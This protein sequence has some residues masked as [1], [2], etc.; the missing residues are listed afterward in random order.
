MSAR[1][2]LAT[3]PAALL[4]VTVALVSLHRMATT[5]PARPAAAP[6]LLPPAAAAPVAP[7][8]HPSVAPAPAA[9]PATAPAVDGAW[10]AR[11]AS[12]TGIPEAALRAYAA[13]QLSGVGGCPV[14]WTTLAGI[15]W[16]ES[17]HGTIDG[18]LLGED[19][20][21]TR[22]VVGPPLD[23]RGDVAAIRSTAASRAWH[24]D[25]VWEHAVGP[26][27]FLRPSF[28]RWAADGDGDGV[29]D[30]HDL[31][32]AAAT[33]ARY[34]CGTGHDLT[35]GEGWVA[36]VLDYNRSTE[37]VEQ[38]RTAAQAYADRSAG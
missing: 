3:A 31:D 6:G 35:T 18:R 10:L 4:A 11:T 26:M 28:D 33:A 5:E 25:A 38:V 8:P 36:A 37:Y 29:A 2:H 13:A 1:R 17:H 32:D 12:L 22:P 30:P 24:G 21:S 7:A 16:V 20:R 15:G 23:G 34:L 27:Q 14:G 19:G 9:A